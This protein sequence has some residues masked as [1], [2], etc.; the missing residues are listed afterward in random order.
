MIWRGS[1]GGRRR[2]GWSPMGIGCGLCKS[3]RLWS[4]R[5]SADGVWGRRRGG[6]GRR[7]GGRR[8][9]RPW[10]TFWA[11]SE[12][13]VVWSDCDMI[14]IR[15]GLVEWYLVLRSGEP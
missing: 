6:G 9:R 14:V 15:E 1:E 8:T 7:E 12:V 11:V 10:R 3:L 4:R 2:R 5:G 13:E